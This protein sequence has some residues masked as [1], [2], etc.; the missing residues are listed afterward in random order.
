[1]NQVIAVDTGLEAFEHV[2]YDMVGGVGYEMIGAR[3]LYGAHDLYGATELVGNDDLNR[4]LAMGADPVAAAQVASMPGRQMRVIDKDPTVWREQYLP[5][6]LSGGPL[7]TVLAGTTVQIVT[8]VQK[9]F[10]CNRLI[11]PSDVAG[12]F[13]VNN[14][15]VGVNPQFAATGSLPGRMFSENSFG[16]KLHGDTAQIGQSITISITNVTAAPLAFVAAMQGF[17]AQ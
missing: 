10:R 6:N 12:G 14:I 8:P 13:V 9:I 16:I 15:A 17:V 7:A 11:I 3:D 1:M 5:I 4:L 2:L